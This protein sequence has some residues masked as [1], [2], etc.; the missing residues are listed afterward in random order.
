MH[1]RSPAA[2]ARAR[3]PPCESIGDV[4][5]TPRSPGP[6]RDGSKEKRDETLS[7]RQSMAKPVGPSAGATMH[8]DRSR[9]PDGPALVR[10]PH[11][12]TEKR[13]A[14]IGDR[15]SKARQVGASARPTIA[16][17]S[18]AAAGDL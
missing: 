14:T 3:G 17:G 2:T 8:E 1:P 16:R 13:D 4:L 7:D 5:Q 10:S 6:S 9:P 12:S 15:K 18:I 11:G